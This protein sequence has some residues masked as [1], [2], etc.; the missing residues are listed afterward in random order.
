M[1]PP[2]LNWHRDWPWHSDSVVILLH[3]VEHVA[4]SQSQSRRLLQSPLSLTNWHC[5]W[6]TLPWAHWHIGLAAHVALAVRREQ[7]IWHV[8]RAAD[9]RQAV[10][11]LQVSALV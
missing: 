1:Q 9:Q 2:L 6:H 8:P 11:A 10:S 3:V 5:D 7:D 4:P